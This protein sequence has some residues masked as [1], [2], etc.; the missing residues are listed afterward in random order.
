MRSLY[1]Q[2]NRPG[3]RRSGDV[4]MLKPVMRIPRQ[5][6]LIAALSGAVFLLIGLLLS[7]VTA[8]DGEDGD[9]RLSARRLDDGRVELALQQRID[10][11]WSARQQP[12]ARFLPTDA[13]AGVWHASSPLMVAASRLL[14][15]ALG[16]VIHH[17]NP[18]D[19]YWRDLEPAGRDFNLN[20]RITGSPQPAEQAALVDECVAAGAAVIATTL[21]APDTLAGSISAA[22]AAGTPIVSF[23]SGVR[24]AAGVGSAIHV[25]L[26]DKDAGT[27]P[28]A[29]FNEAGVEGVLL[30]VIHE[31]FN[32]GLEER[33]DYAETTYEGELERF[34]VHEFGVEDSEQIQLAIAERLSAGDVGAIFT[35]N[36]ELLEVSLAAAEEA[37]VDVEHGTVG[38]DPAQLPLVTSGEV[39]FVLDDLAPLQAYL[40]VASLA[41]AGFFAAQG[42]DATDAFGSV[43]MKIEPVLIDRE[44]AQ[45]EL[46]RLE[47]GR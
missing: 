22:R 8:R 44:R 24:L 47:G 20:L 16:C 21:A 12:E 10:D 27:I 14:D 3:E 2:D 13:D 6:F 28:A 43:D 23:N 5:T 34:R 19:A 17:G 30:C 37:G 15:G 1:Y 29:A 32:V 38:Y 31:E 9:V 4:T 41:I 46:R 18:G 45:K 7:D 11:Q 40:G 26:D 39:L 25:G 42:L 33:C 35:L 36:H